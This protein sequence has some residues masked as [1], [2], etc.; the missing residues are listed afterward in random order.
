MLD[1]DIFFFVELEFNVIRKRSRRRFMELEVK[2][3]RKE[4]S[5]RK[6]GYAS[7]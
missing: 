3:K 4:A 1:W 5:R 6:L 7:N 2:V